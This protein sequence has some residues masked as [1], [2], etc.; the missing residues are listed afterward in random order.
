MPRA[1]AQAASPLTGER[2]SAA[3]VTTPRMGSGGMSRWVRAHGPRMTA[4]RCERD[5][6]VLHPI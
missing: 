2:A 5:A 3:K 6:A 4:F 1:A